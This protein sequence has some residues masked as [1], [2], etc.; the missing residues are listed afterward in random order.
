MEDGRVVVNLMRYSLGLSDELEIDKLLFDEQN[1]QVNV[2]V[3]DSDD[4]LVC[5]ETGEHGMPYDHRK[6]HG[7][8]YLDWHQRKCFHSLPDSTRRSRK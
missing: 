5:I 2:Y 3:S 8:H 1:Q 7:W 4:T 6:A